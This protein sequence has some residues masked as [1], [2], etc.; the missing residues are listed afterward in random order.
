M[1]IYYIRTIYEYTTIHRDMVNLQTFKFGS[2]NP[3]NSSD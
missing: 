1:I 2:L 3:P